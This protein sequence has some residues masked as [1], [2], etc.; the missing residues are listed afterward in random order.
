MAKDWSE[1][2]R[3]CVEYIAKSLPSVKMLVAALGEDALDRYCRRGYFASA[4]IDDV[5]D[6]D[7]CMASED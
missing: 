4:L 2:Q 7:G 6:V 3:R 1:F 5:D